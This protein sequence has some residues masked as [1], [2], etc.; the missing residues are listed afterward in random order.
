L[1]RG[2]GLLALVSRSPG[3]SRARHH[4]RYQ[5]R[6]LPFIRHHSRNPGTSRGFQVS[7]QDISS[8]AK[9]NLVSPGTSRF[10]PITMPG[11]RPSPAKSHPLLPLQNHQQ[12]HNTQ[13]N[14]LQPRMLTEQNGDI[15]H[16]RDITNHAPNHLLLPVQIELVARVQLSVIRVVV[17]ALGEQVERRSPTCCQRGKD[18]PVGEG[19]TYTPL[20]RLTTR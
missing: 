16:K 20:C 6:P 10:V 9:P 5:F 17:V 1:S 15:S 19:I 14:A 13:H 2:P 11:Y 8:R 4:I 12:P 7:S 18:G 3:T